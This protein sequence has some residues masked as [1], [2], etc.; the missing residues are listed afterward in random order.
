[1]ELHKAIKEIVASKGAEMIANPQIINYLLDYQAFKEKPSLKHVFK[2]VI[3]DGYAE[4]IIEIGNDEM[5]QTQIHKYVRIINK[6]Y[7][8]QVELIRELFEALIIALGYS[9][10]EGNNNEIGEINIDEMSIEELKDLCEFYHNQYEENPDDCLEDVMGVKYSKDQVAV[11]KMPVEMPYSYEIRYGT[12][13][14]ADGAF[15]TQETDSHIIVIP[16]TVRA[17]GAKAFENDAYIFDKDK[18]SALEEVT[19]PG[20]VSYIG[21]HAFCGNENLK[22]L[23]L[24]EGLKFIDDWAFGLTALTSVTLP[25]TLEHIGCGVFPYYKMEI[26][27]NSP[28]Y[29]FKDGI[30]Y[31]DKKT[32]IEAVI[33]YD[34]FYKDDG[35]LYYYDKNVTLNKSVEKIEKE[36]F[37]NAHINIITMPNVKRIEEGAFMSS[38]VKEVIFSNRLVYIGPLAFSSCEELNSIN[39]PDSLREID[40]SAFSCCKSLRTVKL[41]NQLRCIESNAFAGCKSLNTIRLPNNLKTLK[42]NPFYHSGIQ[43]IISESSRFRVVDNALY[44]WYEKRIICYFGIDREFTIAYG[45]QVIGEHSFSYNKSIKRL[46]LPNT[47]TKI[48]DRA[49]EDSNIEEINLP[50]SIS[51]LGIMALSSN[52]I[53]EI[54][55]PPQIEIPE[56]DGC[57]YFLVGIGNK[58][59]SVYIPRSQFANFMSLFRYAD[60]T[61]IHIPVG[62]KDDFKKVLSDWYANHQEDA[63]HTISYYLRRVCEYP[64]I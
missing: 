39:L 40:S 32:I 23:T 12:R 22:A 48:E 57:D 49:F 9:L 24:N 5:L 15:M 51:H 27:S 21:D 3:N 58:L 19:I 20:S 42:G 28:H 41:P 46:V 54:K 37:S 47:V 36:A 26:K 60:I 25:S 16:N 50:D 8:F 17:I 2:V 59:K 4:K 7:G 30:L 6:E 31:K 55:V 43:Q 18:E 35:E 64:N 63:S 10:I 44:D 11:V 56:Y 53:Y 14:I 62:T 38:H 33:D 1:M 13:I 45:T 61:K 52:K 34:L 29:I